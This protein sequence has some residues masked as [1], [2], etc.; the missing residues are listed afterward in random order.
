MRTQ[1]IHAA[2][3]ATIV[4]YVGLGPVGITDS[5]DLSSIETEGFHISEATGVTPSDTTTSIARD[6]SP[7][8][9]KAEVLHNFATSF[10]NNVQDLEPS[11]S[12]TVDDNFWDLI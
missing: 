4:C 3:T 8:E 2:A 11:F 7:N 1:I 9:Q 10:L 5:V 12:K 6:F